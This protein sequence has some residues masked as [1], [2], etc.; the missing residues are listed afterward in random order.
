M[1]DNRRRTRTCTAAERGA[2]PSAP[3][4]MP[5]LL[6]MLAPPAFES[7]MKDMRPLSA[8]GTVPGPLLMVAPI[9]VESPWNIVEPPP[10]TPAAEAPS[11]AIAALPAVE[12]WLKSV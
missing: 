3:G 6:L 1:I 7:P 12:V 9:A 11:F 2:P 5:A 10:P 4:T 8:P